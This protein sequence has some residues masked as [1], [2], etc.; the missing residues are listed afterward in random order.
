[1]LRLNVH[2]DQISR[3]QHVDVAKIAAGG[4]HSLFLTHKGQ[5][6]CCGSNSSGQLGLLDEFTLVSKT[7]S[8]FQRELESTDDVILFP[9]FVDIAATEASSIGHHKSGSSC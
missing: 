6:W 7:P 2:T 1:M 4:S 5:L 9:E 8:Q 3:L